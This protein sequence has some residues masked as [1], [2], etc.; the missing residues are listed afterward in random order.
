MEGPHIV[1]GPSVDLQWLVYTGVAIQNHSV[2]HLVVG[3]L[4][5]SK[6]LEDLVA[7]SSV[8]RVGLGLHTEEP[9]VLVEKGTHDDP[10][11]WAFCSRVQL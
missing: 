5:L 2:D 7:P 9:V 11:C 3:H 4:Q 6:Q 10:L 8:E 1:V